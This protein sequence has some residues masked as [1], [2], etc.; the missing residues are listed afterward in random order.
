MRRRLLFIL[1]VLC[2]LCTSCGSPEPNVDRIQTV[3]EFNATRAASEKMLAD[4]GIYKTPVRASYAYVYVLTDLSARCPEP[5]RNESFCM[6]A[7]YTTV[8]IHYQDKCLICGS[9]WEKHNHN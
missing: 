2:A 4:M 9:R 3:E 5:Y 6:T 7:D 8:Q 1:C